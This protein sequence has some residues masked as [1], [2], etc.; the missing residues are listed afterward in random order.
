[1]EEEKEGTGRKRRG[2]REERGRSNNT[3]GEPRINTYSTLETP[4]NSDKFMYPFGIIEVAAWYK[5]TR[6]ICKVTV[7]V[8]R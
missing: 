8:E 6:P 5:P 2:R 4:C 1:M 3:H 7:T